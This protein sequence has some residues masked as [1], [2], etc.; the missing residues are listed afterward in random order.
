MGFLIR[1]FISC[2]A[3]YVASRFIP[4]IVL[5]G[6]L[7]AVKV[8]VVLGLL[9]TFLRPIIRLLTLPITIM[10]LGVFYFVIN[11]LMVY[12]TAYLLPDF[13]ITQIMAAI[14]FSLVMTVVSWVADA[15]T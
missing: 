2:L 14:I 1:L 8:A 11:V 5:T 10:T 3:V 12:L 9:N 7:A 4:G 13:T 6:P 15:V